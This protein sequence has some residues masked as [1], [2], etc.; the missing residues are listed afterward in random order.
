M[1]Y[2]LYLG[3]MIGGGLIL[4]GIFTFIEYSGYREA[5]D[6]G[7]LSSSITGEI[8]D[9]MNNAIMYIIIG[10]VLLGTCG[11]GLSKLG[12]KDEKNATEKF[13]DKKDDVLEK[14]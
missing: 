11:F 13:E 7:S 5:L 4:G 3:L 6:F 2:L 14:F 10:G 8:D 9:I 1:K 12:K